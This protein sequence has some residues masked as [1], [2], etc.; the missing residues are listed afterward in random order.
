MVVAVVASPPQRPALYGRIAQHGKEELHGPRGLECAVRKVAVV[1]S[2]YGKHP[3][4]IG[5]NGHAHGYGTPADPQNPETTQVQCRK[6]QHAHP[7][8]LL[9]VFGDRGDNGII[10]LKPAQKSQPPAFERRCIARDVCTFHSIAS[11]Q[12][13]YPQCKTPSPVRVFWSPLRTQRIQGIAQI[14]Q[15]GQGNGSSLIEKTPVM[16]GGPAAGQQGDVVAQQAA[17]F[18]QLAA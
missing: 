15:I 10:A 13:F 17:Q 6:R 12:L 4:P 8:D 1:K 7:I 9:I 18:D 5:H 11:C 14:A 16:L 3:H 2:G